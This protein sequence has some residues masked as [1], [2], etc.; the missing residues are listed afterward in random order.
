MRKLKNSELD[1]P[2]LSEFKKQQ[3]LPI[4]VILDSVRSLQNVGSCFRTCDAFAV[5]KI[6]L[7]GIT[8]TP[9]HRDINKTA[10]GATQ[11]VEW[12]YRNEVSSALLE[13]KNEG[14][15]IVAVEQ[16]TASTELD[17][18]VP[19]YGRYAF[20]FGNEVTGVSQSAMDLADISLE[21]PQFGTKHSLNISVSVGIVIWDYWQK[22]RGKT[23]I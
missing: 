5:S 8:G 9:P 4:V 14:F 21:I 6:Y 7:C 19:D 20:I 1:R 2:G 10:L 22:N 11:S 3:K 12:E 16:T 15:K 13:L 23:P 17:Q 18:F